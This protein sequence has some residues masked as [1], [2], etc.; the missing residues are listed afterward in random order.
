MTLPLIGAKLLR[1]SKCTKGQ[2]LLITPSA[3]RE[4]K[5]NDACLL[6]YIIIHYE[7]LDVCF[8]SVT[9]VL[10][11]MIL[12]IEQSPCL[13]IRNPL[14]FRREQHLRPIDDRL[15]V[16]PEVI[17]ILV[18]LVNRHVHLPRFQ[19]ITVGNPCQCF[20]QQ[21]LSNRIAFQVSVRH[22]CSNTVPFREIVLGIHQPRPCISSIQ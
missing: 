8:Q 15:E 11:G 3:V 14:P 16:K 13:C 1:F 17:G 10:F 6:G 4:D 18:M 21:L 20:F 9:V 12:V 2:V 5:R 22:L 7:L 19:T